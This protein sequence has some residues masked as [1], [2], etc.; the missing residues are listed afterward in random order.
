MLLLLLLLEQGERLATTVELKEKNSMRARADSFLAAKL[1]STVL[2]R[3]HRSAAMALSV[4]VLCPAKA[5]SAHWFSTQPRSPPQAGRTAL[6]CSRAP[7]PNG[8]MARRW[9]Q[10]SSSTCDPGVHPKM[11]GA[12]VRK[13]N[14]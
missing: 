6:S 5:G 13:A 3:A 14:G 8:S 7:S 4:E 1:G 2:F 11:H 9:L 10:W 12:K